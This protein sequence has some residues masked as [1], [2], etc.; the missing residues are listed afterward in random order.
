MKT[1]YKAD[2]KLYK[3]YTLSCSVINL[4]KCIKIHPRTRSVSA[5]LV[6]IIQLNL[7]DEA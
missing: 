1:N 4:S 5:P 3:W 7:E 6:Y 2:K